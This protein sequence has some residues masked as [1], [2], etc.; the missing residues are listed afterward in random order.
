MP[1]YEYKCKDCGEISE[2]LIN[3]GEGVNDQVCKNCKSADLEKVLSVTNVS[4]YPSPKN[5]KT[6]CGSGE[7]CGQQKRCC[8]S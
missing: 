2:F 7:G 3:A 6:C 8:E 1:L 5:G 4:K